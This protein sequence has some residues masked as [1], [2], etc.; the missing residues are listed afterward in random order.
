MITKDNGGELGE[1]LVLF[2]IDSVQVWDLA[3]K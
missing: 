1:M 3:G 2:Q